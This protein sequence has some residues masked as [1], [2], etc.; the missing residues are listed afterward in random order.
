[1]LREKE[2]IELKEDINSLGQ[3]VM[4]LTTKDNR[5]N[6]QVWRKIFCLYLDC[7]IFFSDL[8]QEPHRNSAA[9]AQERLKGFSD[10]L[11]HTNLITKIKSNNA[12]AMLARFS[13]VNLTL[14]HYL[15]F[16]EL[17]TVAVAKILKSEQ[18]FRLDQLRR[19]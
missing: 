13:R 12:H 19:D 3:A 15:Q 9:V 4:Q 11:N 18:R 14:L 17:N 6:M 8:E 5:N 16:Q 1:M 2:E 10:K 7:N